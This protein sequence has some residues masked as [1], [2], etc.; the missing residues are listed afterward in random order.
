MIAGVTDRGFPIAAHLVIGG[1]TPPNGIHNALEN[2]E[3][4]VQ[5]LTFDDVA[6][7]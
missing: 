5:R 7:D 6:L 4:G 1:A 2:P 3:I